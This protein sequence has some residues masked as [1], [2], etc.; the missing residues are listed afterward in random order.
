M[1]FILLSDP[2]ATLMKPIGR[3]DNVG[4]AFIKKFKFVLN[5]AKKRGFPIFIPGDLFDR[6]MEWKAMML[7]MDLIK[8]SKVDIY[9]VYGQHDMYARVSKG[10]IT[11]I[12]ILIKSGIVNLL[13]SKPTNIY[14]IMVYGSSWNE[15]IPIPDRKERNMLVTHKPVYQNRLF[16]GQHGM[17]VES[18]A[19]KHS[20]YNMIHV[21]DIHRRFVYKGNNVVVNTG[22]LLRLE[23]T[24]Y[25]IRHKP[26]FAIYNH[27]ENTIEFVE[28]PHKPG[29]EVLDLT[30]RKEIKRRNEYLDQLTTSLKKVDFRT[31]QSDVREDVIKFIKENEIEDDIVKALDE[32]MVESDGS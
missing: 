28:V 8:K 16:P 9:V 11:S 32:I 13:K 3:V 26:S 23:A 2:H 20:L 27:I 15:K 18:F 14:G 29:R 31:Y 5:Y 7:I 4:K 21:G 6:A 19:K 17:D 22:P 1:N 12:N 30:H 25:N 24:R 10:S